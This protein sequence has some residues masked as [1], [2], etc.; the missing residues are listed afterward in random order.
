[1]VHT[2]GDR[3]RRALAQWRE[4]RRCQLRSVRT[5]FR[6]YST[7]PGGRNAGRAALSTREDV[8]AT[9]IR[10]LERTRGGARTSSSKRLRLLGVRLPWLRDLRLREGPAPSTE[11]SGRSSDESSSE[12]SSDS[13]STSPFR[14]NT[15]RMCKSSLGYKGPLTLSVSHASL[16]PSR[17]SAPPSSHTIIRSAPSPSPNRLDKFCGRPESMTC[18]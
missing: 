11:S 10:A 17:C 8:A 18:T 3:C 16:S 12:L 5:M 14:S 9:R 4:G 13:G 7:C 15:I 6:T 1:M 2:R